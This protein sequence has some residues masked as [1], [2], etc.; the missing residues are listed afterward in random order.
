LE[1]I[2]LPCAGTG[3]ANVWICAVRSATVYS[4]ARGAAL[5]AMSAGRIPVG[6]APGA[7]TVKNVF[8]NRWITWPNAAS[9]LATALVNA[10]M[11]LSQEIGSQLELDRM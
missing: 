2:A 6:A 7:I 8:V 4:A 11:S 1:T 9:M 5:A 10:S 3:L